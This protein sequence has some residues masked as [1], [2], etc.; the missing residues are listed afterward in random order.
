M[1]NIHELRCETAKEF[2]AYI[3]GQ[4]IEWDHYDAPL[5]IGMFLEDQRE[6]NGDAE[7]DPAAQV[8]V[9]IESNVDAAVMEHTDK[10]SLEEIKELYRGAVL[11]CVLGQTYEQTAYRA[12]ADE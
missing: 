3:S 7:A 2:M 8:Q 10:K 9:R 6:L 12:G 4:G 11:K 1:K 5:E